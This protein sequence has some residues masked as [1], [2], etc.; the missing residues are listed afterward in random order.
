MP[1]SRYIRLKRDFFIFKKFIH[2]IKKFLKIHLPE[3]KVK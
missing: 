2:S 1:K 3:V